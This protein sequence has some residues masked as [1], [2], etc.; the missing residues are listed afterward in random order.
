M[1][2]EIIP[3]LKMYTKEEIIQYLYDNNKIKLEGE[4]TFNLM[5][6]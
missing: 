2:E 1:N 3:Q 6:N 5:M 4:G